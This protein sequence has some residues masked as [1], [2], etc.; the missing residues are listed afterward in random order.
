MKRSLIALLI[1]VHHFSVS[2]VDVDSLWSVFNDSSIPDTVR[3]SAIKTMAWDGFLFS[4]PD[5]AFALAQY[6][7]DFARQVG[8]KIM[9][10]SGYNT[11]GGS[12]YLRGDY[13]QAIEYYKKSL[14]IVEELELE[15]GIA[16][17]LNNIAVIYQGQGALD[18]AI[19]YLTR[20]LKIHEQMKMEDGTIGNKKGMGISHNNIGNIYW[21]QE[22]YEKAFEHY[23]S[24]LKIEEEIGFKP[25][26]AGALNNIGVYYAEMG[27]NEKALECYNRGIEI[28]REIGDKGKEADFLN[29]LGN[30]HSGQDNYEKALEFFQQS[31]AI[32]IEIDDKPGQSVGKNNLATIY[33]KNGDLNYAIKLGREA[34]GLAQEAQIL[35]ET[36]DA[37][38]NL[39]VSYK[40][41]GQPNKSLEMYELYI[42]SRDSIESEEN[43]REILNQQFKY[44]YEKKEAVAA[45]EYKA[46]LDHQEE[47]ALAEQRRQ[48]IIIGS[49][50]I[51][52]ILVALFSVFLFNRFKITQR[53]KGIIERQKEIVE[54]KNHQ[55]MDSIQ[56]AKRIQGAILPP[57]KLVK[58][59][60]NE[61]FILYKP[62]DIV[63]G[64]F[65]WMEQR[66]GK[67]LF[68]AA[69][70][71]GHGVPGALVS[72]VCNN[73]LNRSVREFG[74]TEP[75][76]IL[77]KTREI[78]I[79]EF[80]KSEE[81]VKDGMDIALCSLE[82]NKLSYAGAH[83]PLWIIRSGKKEIEEIKANKQP[84]GQF[85]E[86]KP[87][88]THQLDL[89]SGDSI[90]IF[91]DGIVDQFGGDRNKKF[92]PANFRRLLISIQEMKMEDQGRKIE[93]TFEEWKGSNAQ[94]DDVCVIGVKV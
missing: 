90:Y 59:N 37:A 46:E 45:A 8:D 39:Y 38:Q 84:I 72:V 4:N 30:L 94:L 57:L 87:Y 32:R 91:S 50:S 44:E 48:N 65:Y 2:Q 22:Q 28:S 93:E 67:L 7:V 27:D 77:D 19:E 89:E 40:S 24:A 52:L 29:S 14:A 16:S 12:F 15:D 74:I 1:F 41:A 43:Q 63:A 66:D 70:C 10:G 13:V 31:L 73:G 83:N 58:E 55:I 60:F 92:R 62:K 76:K 6:Q 80:E 47:I 51:G 5:S 68:A 11:Q 9:E 54:E 86:Q 18:K 53:Q 88:T 56:Y 64:D 78:V 23:E 81:E 33:R 35:E 75:G 61:S 20:S 21:D 85:D 26:I 42:Q 79:K 49:I 25:G 71:T 3:L 36:R 34:L 17:T 69:D 82:G